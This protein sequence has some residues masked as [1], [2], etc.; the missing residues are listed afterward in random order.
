MAGSVASLK[1]LQNGLD[2]VAAYRR[3]EQ[4][5]VDSDRCDRMPDEI[6]CR[7]HTA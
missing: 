3:R 4:R 7:R 1:T 6:M 2:F 5:G